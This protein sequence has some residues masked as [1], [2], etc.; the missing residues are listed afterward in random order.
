MKVMRQKWIRA[1]YMVRGW[2]FATLK[3]NIAESLVYVQSAQ[4]LWEEIAERYGQYNAPLLFK[5]K[6]DLQQNNLSVGEYYCKLKSLACGMIEGIPTCNCGAMSN[7]SCNILK[8]M[9]EMDS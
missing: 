2:L 6:N 9:V 5:L 3:V 4:Q 8:K 1:D 7:C